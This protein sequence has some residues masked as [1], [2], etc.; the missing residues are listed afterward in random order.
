MKRG[1]W[2]P[3]ISFLGALVYVRSLGYFRRSPSYVRSAPV[4]SISS[5]TSVR[6]LCLAERIQC[7]TIARE[8]VD[9]TLLYLYIITLLPWIRNT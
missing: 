9:F 8:I 4:G 6:L 3:L 7:W 2:L 5:R 1:D